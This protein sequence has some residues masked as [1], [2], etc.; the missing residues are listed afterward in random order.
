MLVEPYWRAIGPSRKELSCGLYR[1]AAGLELRCGYEGDDLLRSTRIGPR[2]GARY[3]AA[4]WLHV[5]LSNGAFDVAECQ[6]SDELGQLR[7]AIDVQAAGE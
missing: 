7:A 4:G 6:V 3:T 1:T 5:V 2:D